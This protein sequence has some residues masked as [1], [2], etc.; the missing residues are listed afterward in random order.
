MAD[1]IVLFM[2]IAFCIQAGFL[3]AFASHYGKVY[4]TAMRTTLDALIG[5]CILLVIFDL[6][7]IP[8]PSFAHI[9]PSQP[10]YSHTLTH[11]YIYLR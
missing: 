2:A 6:Y 10:P 4:V 7:F 11:T 1:M 9:L 3:V 5:N 8:Y